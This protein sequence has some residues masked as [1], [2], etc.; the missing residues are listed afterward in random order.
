MITFSNRS[1]KDMPCEYMQWLIYYP[2]DYKSCSYYSKD[3]DRRSEESKI[4]S[5]TKIYLIEE[6]LKF[7][8]D[9]L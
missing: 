3:R 5:Y 6:N 4:Y 9:V 8:V 7:I 1:K 2:P